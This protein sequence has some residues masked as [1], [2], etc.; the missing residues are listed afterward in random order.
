MC[1]RV[2]L[3]YIKTYIQIIYIIWT[4]WSV[5]YKILLSASYSRCRRTFK[6]KIYRIIF[7]ADSLPD[8]ELIKIQGRRCFFVVVVNKV[9]WRCTSV[10]ERIFHV[11]FMSRIETSSLVVQ[12]KLKRPSIKPGTR[13]IPEHSGTF[14][15]IPEHPGTWKNKNNFHEKNIIK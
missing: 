14:R 2:K 15:N 7:S 4:Q 5:I 9:P 3:T 13:N 12:L 8:P 10:W 1:L 11:S 6:L